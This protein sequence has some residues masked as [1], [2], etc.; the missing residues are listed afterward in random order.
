[1]VRVDPGECVLELDQSRKIPITDQELNDAF[2]LPQGNRIIP[3]V[4]SDLSEVCIEFSRLASSISTKGVHSLK[5]TEFILSKPI[6]ENSCKVECECFKIAFVIFSVRHVLNPCVK[7]D[8]TSVDY[9]AALVVP[10]EMNSY[11]WCRFVKDSLMKGVR[12]IKSDIANDN[13][14]IHI[15]GC[16]LL[17]QVIALDKIET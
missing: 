4:H 1:M 6:D 3:P 2:G 13:N 11:N 9:W 5:A 10:S 15:V 7:H 16:H 17:L 12:K 8:Y 14:T